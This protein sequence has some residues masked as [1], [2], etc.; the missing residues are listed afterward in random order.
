MRLDVRQPVPAPAPRQIRIGHDIQGQART[1]DRL[2]GL[3][4]LR[5]AW[6]VVG[7]VIGKAQ[8]NI[9]RHFR[10][11]RIMDIPHRLAVEGRF[12]QIQLSR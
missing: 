1:A 5:Q 8:L 10:P 9:A 7:C 2:E 4:R 11:R 6:S 3:H 12:I